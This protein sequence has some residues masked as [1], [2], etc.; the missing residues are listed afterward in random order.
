MAR[1]KCRDCPRCTESAMKG[2]LVAPVRLWVDVF[3]T[4]FIWPFRKM[5]PLCKHPLAWHTRDSAG[6]FHD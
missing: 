3:R 6:R 5:C 1:Q 4:L 2:C